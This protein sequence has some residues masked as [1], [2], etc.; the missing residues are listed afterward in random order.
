M[1]LFILRTSFKKL[2]LYGYPITRINFSIGILVKDF[3]FSSYCIIYLTNE[4][5]FDREFLK[6]LVSGYKCYAM[7]ELHQF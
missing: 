3:T 5:C 7:V 2:F 1:L 6:Y 4:S